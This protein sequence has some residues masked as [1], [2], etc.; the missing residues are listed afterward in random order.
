ME[1]LGKEL[2][3]VLLNLRHLQQTSSWQELLDVVLFDCNCS[4]VT[5]V[6]K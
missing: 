1:L 4:S 6:N 2:A 5:K 3:A